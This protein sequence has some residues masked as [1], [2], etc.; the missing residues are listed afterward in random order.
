MSVS[1]SEFVTRAKVLYG[2]KYD[3]SKVQWVNTQIK[4]CI[5]C[6][7]HGEWWT[8]PNNF[9]SGHKC[10]A[11]SGR[12]RITKEIFL[13]RSK[14]IHKNRYDY[15][16]VEW[17]SPNTEVCIICPIHGD[18]FQKPRNH[19]LGMG[20]QKCFGSPKSST[21]EFI[22]KAKAIYGDTY[23]YSK[24]EYKGNKEKVCII[25]PKHGEW[26]M[27]PNNHLRGHRCPGCYG[28]PK[29]TVEEF[30]SMAKK[31]HG[32]KYDYS[33]VE[34]KGN[35]IKVCI[36]C[37]EHGEFWQKPQS[38]LNG[39]GCSKCSGLYKIDLPLFIEHCT[40][41]HN[42]KYDYS[43]VKFNNI[44]D[45]VTIICPKHGEFKQRAK[46]HYIGYGCTICAGNK[47]LT[48]EEFIEKAELVHGKKYDYSKV[49]YINTSTK[50]CIICPFHGEFWQTP[51]AHLF[52]AGCPT[53]PQSNLEGEI[54]NFL[55]KNNIKFEQEKTFTWLVH[56]LRMYL[57][58]FL[59]EYGV[60]I[61]CQGG[62]HFFPT[63]LFGGK[64]F[65]QLTIERDK[66]KKKLCE[67]HGINILYY[68]HADVNYPYPVFESVRLLLKAI[69]QNGHFKPGDWLEEPELPFEFD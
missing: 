67:K 20:C 4:V 1:F 55:I 63:D 65:Y 56:K 8:T 16:K 52:G 26:W 24:V 7:E 44:N 38:H 12:L 31:V 39:N 10:P 42:K 64:D 69:K 51:N 21:E 5:I 2:D 25:C 45:Y 27:S 23:D 46:N 62:Q 13:S 61:E 66:A 34:Y 9:L 18:F 57:D 15:S 35:K 47:R 37:P 43:K 32:N 54:R 60:A 50:V 58:F 53:C 33:K 49:N 22:K 3:Y 59:P 14:E 40:A 48:N 30:V 28:T 6:P 29:H 17:K 19:L 11:C 68:S 36:L 41:I